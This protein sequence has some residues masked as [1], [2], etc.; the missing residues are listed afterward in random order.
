MKNVTNSET[1]LH[2]RVPHSL[3]SLH[4]KSPLFVFSTSPTPSNLLTLSLVQYGEA[5][6]HSLSFFP[7]LATLVECMLC[8]YLQ[9]V[10][11]V[12]TQQPQRVGT[13]PPRW[14]RRWFDSNMELST[15]WAEMRRCHCFQTHP[16]PQWPP[17]AILLTLSPDDHHR[18]R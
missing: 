9:Q 13:R 7:L 17:L 18:P 2:W 14:V 10:Q 16:Q 4:Y 3:S 1:L 11:R 12:P 8:Y 6:L 5:L 15:P